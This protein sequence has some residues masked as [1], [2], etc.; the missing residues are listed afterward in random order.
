M[1]TREEHQILL[2]RQTPVKTSFLCCRQSNLAANLFVVSYTVVS[3]D[4][5][6]ASRWLDERGDD[7]GQGR[8]ARAVASNQTKDLACL[9]FK[10]NIAKCLDRIIHRTAKEC[11]EPSKGDG[12]SF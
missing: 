10:R 6:P 11:A 2:R 4:S 7:L 12:V 8:L 5:D 1:K 3:A 9:N